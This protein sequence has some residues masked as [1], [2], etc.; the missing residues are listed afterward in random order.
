MFESME[1]ESFS[2]DQ[3]EQELAASRIARSRLDAHDIEILEVLDARQVATADGSRSLSEWVAARLDLSQDTARTL[4]RT[5]RRTT[6]GPTCVIPSLQGRSR[7][8]G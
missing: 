7:W 5:M 8:T 1:W 2:T 6:I 4:V 3:L